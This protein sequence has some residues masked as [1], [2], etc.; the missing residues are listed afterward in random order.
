MICDPKING[1]FML[2]DEDHLSADGSQFLS[3]QIQEALK[4]ALGL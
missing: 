3:P 4:S 1:E 2:E